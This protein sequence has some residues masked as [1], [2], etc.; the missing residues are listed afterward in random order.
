M[1]LLRHLV[2]RNN[3]I[4]WIGILKFEFS[5][6]TDPKLKLREDKQFDIIYAAKSE[7]VLVEK[8]LYEQHSQGICIVMGTL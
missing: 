5:T 3:V 1:I 6:T 2:W 4:H 8:Y 7:K